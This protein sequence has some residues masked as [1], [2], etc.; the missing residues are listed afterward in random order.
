MA[1]SLHDLIAHSAPEDGGEPQ[2]LY[3]HARNV[4]G[5]AAEFAA[6]FESETIARWLGWWHDAGK[7]HP[8]VQDYLTADDPS[9]PGPDHSSVGMLK[10]DEV[11]GLLAHNIAGHHGGLANQSGENGLSDRIR[12]K[13]TDDRIGEALALAETLVAAHAPSIGA[14]DLPGFLQ[15]LGAESRTKRGYEFWLRMLHSALV[16]ADCLDTERH[17][18]PERFAARETEDSISDLWAQFEENQRALMAEAEPTVV[19]RRRRD[20]YEAAIDAAEQPPGVFSMTVP[21]GGGK[22]RSAMGFGLRHARAHD[23]NRVIV[24]LPYTSII[25]QNADV[26]REIFGEQV[27]LEHHSAVRAEAEPGDEAPPERWRRLAT[28]NWDAPV[29]VTT[30]VQLLESLFTNHNGRLR[31]LHRLANSVVVLD[32]VQ[33]LPPRLMNATL[34]GL[35]E[36]KAHYGASILLCTATQPALTERPGFP[37]GLDERTEIVPDPAGLYDDL[38]RVEYDVQVDAPWTWTDVADDL[39]AHRQAMAVLNTKDDAAAVLDE[40]PADPSILHLSTRLCGAHRRRVLAEVRCRLQ[41]DEPVRLVATQ[42][43]EAG[44][45]LSFPRVL[46]ALGPL[47]SII[48]AAGRC[49]RE[50][51]RDVGEVTVFRPAAGDKPYGNTPQGAYLR[52]CSIAWQLFQNDPDLDLHDPTVPRHYFRQLYDSSDL[53]EADVQTL[54]AEFQFEQVADEY[55]LIEDDTTPVVVNY[56][57]GWSILDDVVETAE[58]TEFVNRADGRRLQP[59]TV[60][61]YEHALDEA[62]RKGNAHE[63][64]PDLDLWRWDGGY[65]AGSLHEGGTDGGRG[66]H[67]EGPTTD[68]LIV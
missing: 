35:R 7:A 47:D 49:N 1:D 9:P 45:D 57:D 34:D 43:V 17:F 64:V 38:R 23:K 37:E 5:M 60:S 46:R 61:L 52:G 58:H 42:V 28:Q 10:A 40:L 53:D 29:V 22:T 33:T 66:L 48:Q 26:Y 11:M 20:V 41:D 13:R 56:G 4:A 44:V 31:K 32:E 68:N 2:S 3:C 16:D 36:L 12:S 24:A 67:T 18:D 55:R 39:M 6:P 27:V 21:T 65:D 19:N 59:Y 63:L 50:G 62:V 51:E 14:R 54:R 8:A 30:T 25:E 15:E